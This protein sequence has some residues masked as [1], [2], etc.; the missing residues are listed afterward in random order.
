MEQTVETNK[1]LSYREISLSFTRPRMLLYT[2]Y[3]QDF[4]RAKL[5]LINKIKCVY[6]NSFP[7]HMGGHRFKHDA[8]ILRSLK[9]VLNSLQSRLVMKLVGLSVVAKEGERQRVRA[10][11]T[12]FSQITAIIII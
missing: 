2:G 6:H 11:F 1:R 5:V 10:K 8:I 3:L 4:W 9:F 12:P 7:S